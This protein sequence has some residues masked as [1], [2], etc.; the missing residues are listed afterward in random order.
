MSET[1]QLTDEPHILKRYLPILKWL[2]QYQRSWLRYDIVAG[3]AVWAVLVPTSMA[4]AGIAGMPPETGLYAA[5]RAGAT[6][7]GCCAECRGERLL[8]GEVKQGQE[9]GT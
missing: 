8:A 4:Y 5:P 6:A 7:L 2:P 1:V 3:L 9:E